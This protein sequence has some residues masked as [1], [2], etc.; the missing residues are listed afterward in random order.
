V[1]LASSA[2]VVELMAQILS[3]TAAVVTIDAPTSPFMFFP[4]LSATMGKFSFR[5]SKPAFPAKRVT[6]DDIRPISALATENVC[7]F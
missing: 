5:K 7:Q 2:P 1:L 4:L 3:A 6:S